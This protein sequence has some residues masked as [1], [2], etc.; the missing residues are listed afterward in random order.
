[1]SSI[2][3]LRG[4]ILLTAELQSDEDYKTVSDEKVQHLPPAPPLGKDNGGLAR[5]S[6]VSASTL[7]SLDAHVFVYRG[8]NVVKLFRRCQEVTWFDGLPTFRLT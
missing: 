3:N 8:Q 7:R 1:M 2:A 6:S 4:D 5:S